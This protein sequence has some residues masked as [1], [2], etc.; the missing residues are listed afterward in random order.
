MTVTALIRVLLL[1]FIFF[2]LPLFVQASQLPDTGQDV[3][4]N[5][6]GTVIG[7]PDPGQSFHGQDAQYQGMVRSYTKLGHGGQELPDDARHVDDGGDWIM[8]RDNVTGL[9]WEVKTEVNRENTY[10]W[11]AAG[12]ECIAALNEK[13]FGGFTD[14]RMPSVHELSSIVHCGAAR[15]AL[16]GQ[17]FPKPMSSDYWTSSTDASK[18]SYAWRISFVGGGTGVKD[19]SSS[20]HVRA[21]RGGS[22][23]G[24]GDV[25]DN[26]DGTVTDPRTGLEW[27]KVTATGTY[28]WEAALNYAESLDLGGHTDWRLPNCNE[29]QSL[30]DYSRN[31]PAVPTTLEESTESSFYWS[32]TTEIFYSTNRAWSVHFFSGSAGSRYKSNTSCVRCVRGGGV[33]KGR[34]EKPGLV[35]WSF[36]TSDRIYSSPAV[37]REGTVYV[38]SND[39]RLYAIN[40]EGDLKWFYTTEAPI[41][42]SPAIDSDGTI[43]IASGSTLYA[44]RSDRTQE[45][46]YQADDVISTSPVI[47]QDGTIYFGAEDERLYALSQAGDLKWKDFKAECGIRSAVIGGDDTIYVG[48]RDNNIYAVGEDS[49]LKWNHE[50]GGNVF[51]PVID[52][53][54]NIYFGSLDFDLYSF[55]IDGKRRWDL[56]EL[57]IYTLTIGKDGTLYA[58]QGSMIRDADDNY[59]DTYFYALK[60]DS[61]ILWKYKTDGT[62]SSSLVGSNGNIY[63]PGGYH[64]YALNAD[65]SLEWKLDLGDY[66]GSN[67]VMSQDGIMYVGSTNGMLYAISTGSEGLARS[68]WPMFQ[69]DARH[70]GR[71]WGGVYDWV[72]DVNGDREFGLDDIILSFQACCGIVSEDTLNMD[73]DVNGDGSVG[74]AEAIYVLRKNADMAVE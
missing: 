9:I 54:G 11:D 37:D 34:P 68:P 18:S 8:T 65:G 40:P 63:F 27:Q 23:D 42:T 39:N 58:G 60:P 3:C 14:W 57:A 50:T 52:A 43:Y 59:K 25:V 74:L 20:Y 38:G 55:G 26:G 32:S 29:L 71:L 44:F 12:N 16:D 33:D 61:T 7:C 53:D 10:S 45:W 41:N 64:I 2:V 31:R 67:P 35:K 22:Y 66:I 28:T 13:G 30:V 73:V 1:G 49:S 15:P 17:W 6:E 21:V 48:S 24:S 47:G 36:Q 69:H 72:G 56:P 51:D 62:C 4:Y 19:T 46:T 70:T 5:A